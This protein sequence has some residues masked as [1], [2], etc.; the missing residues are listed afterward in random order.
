MKQQFLA[1][2]SRVRRSTVVMLLAGPVLAF[3]LSQFILGGWP[4]QYGL[5]LVLANSICYGAIYYLLCALTGRVVLSF[6][7][8]QLIA[9][10]WAAANHFVSAFRGTPVLPWDFSALGTAAAVAGSYSFV[11]TWQMLVVVLILAAEM[12]L[13]RRRLFSRRPAALWLPRAAAACVGVLCVLA[14]RP[15]VL[16]RLDVKT[17]VW[18]PAKAY[19]ETGAL[20]SFICN[21]AFMQV[22]KPEGY[23]AEAVQELLESQPE[24]PVA[25]DPPERPNVI[26]IM[27]ESWADFEE[28]GNLSL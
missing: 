3:Y 2:L 13:L 6:V 28:W 8:I 27:N 21:T 14:A 19:R 15:G 22:E 17:D 9:G 5:S 4:W 25:G 7:L 20:A 18:N 23:S 11:P 1:G 26:A 10:I 16:S 12:V 24:L